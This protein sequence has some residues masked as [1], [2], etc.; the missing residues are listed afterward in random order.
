VFSV[1][2]DYGLIAATVDVPGSTSV[3]LVDNSG[4]GF[5][6]LKD[7]SMAP[8]PYSHTPP[9]GGI[10]TFHVTF[11]DGEH[12]VFTNTITSTFLLP[13]V[14]DS[15]Y[16][17]PFGTD[18]SVRLKWEPV[19][20]A[21]FYQIRISSGDNEIQPWG[22]NTKDATALS[23]ERLIWNFS[24]YLPGTLLFEVRAVLYE[25][26]DETH[27]QAISQTSAAIDL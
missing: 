27:V 1:T 2:S 11:N 4:T 14:I 16:K 13:P 8:G 9:A 23:F 22:L 25:P 21:Q 10:Y 20:N 12:K 15:L 24:N 18:Q 6:F 26:S 7:T 19:V 5:T 3:S 17:K